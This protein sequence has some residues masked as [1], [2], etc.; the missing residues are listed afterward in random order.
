MRLTCKIIQRNEKEKK[1]KRPTYFLLIATLVA[2]KLHPNPNPK[3]TNC[4]IKFV[5]IK[6]SFKNQKLNQI[7]H[8]GI[9]RSSKLK[10]H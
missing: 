1:K 7:L 2:N 10:P 4:P 3:Q 6:R 8:N 5:G 9:K